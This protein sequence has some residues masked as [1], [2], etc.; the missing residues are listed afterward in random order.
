MP[1]ELKQRERGI[2]TTLWR[3]TVTLDEM[4][5]AQALGRKL[6]EEDGLTHYILIF[7]MSTKPRILTDIRHTGRLIGMDESV[8]RTL[9]VGGSESLKLFSVTLMRVFKQM[10]PIEHFDTMDDAL[11]FARRTLSD[12]QSGTA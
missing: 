3:D 8:L 11:A 1:I 5:E 6:A 12:L 2:Y 4:A 10:N 9:I 7:D